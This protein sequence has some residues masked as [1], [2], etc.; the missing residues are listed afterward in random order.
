MTNDFVALLKV[1][2]SSVL[3]VL[4]LT[5]ETQILPP[6]LAVADSRHAR[7]R[8]VSGY[9]AL[10][11]V[12]AAR[13]REGAP[14]VMTRSVAGRTRRPCQ[15]KRRILSAQPRRRPARE[16]VA[17]MGRPAPGRSP[18]PRDCR[19]SRFNP[20]RLPSTVSC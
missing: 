5:K 18:C 16:V 1:P 10:A 15:R 8:S 12:A 7:R 3:T 20:D 4:E 14:G 13:Q 19:P 2:R 11:T 9:R 17:I 6:I